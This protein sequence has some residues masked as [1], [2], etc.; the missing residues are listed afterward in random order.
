MGIFKANDIRG[1]YPVELDQ[2]TL[3]SIGFYLPH[4]LK[5]D[6]ILVGRDTRTSSNEVFDILSKGITDNGADVV[7]IGL[8]DT[9][10]VYF[11]TAFY[12]F[13]GSVMITASHNPPEYNGLKISRSE[14]IP[15]GPDTG[16]G[17]FES[18]IKSR[19][20]PVSKKGRITNLDISRD[21]KN[22][23]RKFMSDY[24]G[25]Q[26][27][28][29]CG[30]AAA[31]A[32][33][34]KIFAGTSLHF[35]TLFDEPNGTFPNHGPNPLEKESWVSINKEILKQKADLGII[36]DGDA[37]RA[38]FFDEKG[39]FI[40]PDII[41]ALIGH[42]YYDKKTDPGSNI[43]DGQMYYDIRSSRSVSEYIETLGGKS[44]PCR[45]GHANIKKIL[46][47]SNGTYA[48]ELSGHYYF[49]ENYFCDSGFIAAAVVLGII[50]KLQV[51]VS[52]ISGK[53]NPYSFSGEINFEV[54]DQKLILTKIE[55]YFP[56]GKVN[57]LDGVRIDFNS[58][59][60]IL[61]PSR[62]EPLLRLVVEAESNEIMKEKIKELKAIIESFE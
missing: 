13:D 44:S 6:K 22:H 38:V 10:A 30:N 32:Y 62:A 37:D 28:F 51:P 56:E 43:S 17:E 55:E 24:S 33:V 15:V 49:R 35:T 61:T 47:E 1:K 4:I 59:W 36:F 3:Y 52:E 5:T 46:K 57:R 12:K 42:Y 9:P 23:I 48:G 50:K 7:D 8:C 18:L 14:A 11:A 58:W 45:T 21:Y 54:K 20:V 53:I 40:S 41:T 16:L 27:V 39:G 2:E 19:T 26:A 25:I 60:F 34:H 29:D 31:V